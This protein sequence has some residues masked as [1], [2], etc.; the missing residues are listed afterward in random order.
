MVVLPEFSRTV[1]KTTSFV[2]SGE[3]VLPNEADSLS[4]HDTFSC[5]SGGRA[6]TRN[7]VDRNVLVW[8]IRSAKEGM[9]VFRW[10][11]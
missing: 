2:S 3:V 11:T 7:A 9:Q 4:L 5:V 6:V 10:F 8:L 1:W